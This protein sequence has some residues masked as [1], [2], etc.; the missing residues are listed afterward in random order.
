MTVKVACVKVPLPE[1]FSLPRK[2][3]V[4][5]GCLT[6]KAYN[7]LDAVIAE[8]GAKGLY[9]RGRKACRKAQF[10]RKSVLNH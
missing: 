1:D 10:V 6:Q 8:G 5:W 9:F 3:G 4:S 2:F 7:G